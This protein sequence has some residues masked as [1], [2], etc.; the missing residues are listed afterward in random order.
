MRAMTAIL[1][2]LTRRRVLT[3]EL[4]IIDLVTVL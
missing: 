2:C 1:E 3:E 4:A